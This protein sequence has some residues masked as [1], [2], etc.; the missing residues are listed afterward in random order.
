MGGLYTNECFDTLYLGGGG[1]GGVDYALT[2]VL[3]H[4][5]KV[6]GGLYTNESFDTLY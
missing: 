4:C 1:G 6:G 2:S 3:I 5:T